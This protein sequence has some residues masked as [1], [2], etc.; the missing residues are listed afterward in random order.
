MPVIRQDICLPC[1]YTLFFH[2]ISCYIFHYAAAQRAAILMSI[3][4][5]ARLRY[6]F[7]VPRV[8]VDMLTFPSS[9]S[10]FAARLPTRLPS[11]D[12]PPVFSSITIGLLRLITCACCASCRYAMPSICRRRCQPAIT[13]EA[14]CPTRLHWEPN[15][16]FSS[17]VCK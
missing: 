4:T 16:L 14:F 3:I 15:I 13:I 11:S 6:H 9:M 8:R 12:T 10:S 7:L 5:A 2:D 1:V 17:S